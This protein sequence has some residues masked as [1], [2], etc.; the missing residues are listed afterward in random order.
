M[1]DD[2]KERFDAIANRKE[3][4]EK[5]PD[6]PQ[7]QDSTRTQLFDLLAVAQK[8]GMYDAADYLKQNLDIR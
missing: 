8:L 4:L 3:L 2:V 1:S 6:L 7:R 5:I